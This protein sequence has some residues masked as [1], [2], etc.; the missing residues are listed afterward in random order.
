MKV[1]RQQMG[2]EVFF[3]VSDLSPV[4]EQAVSA[5]AFR[6]MEGT[7]DG[8][9]M[10]GYPADSPHLDH[11]FAN[12]ERSIETLIRQKAG[13]IPVAW[14]EALLYTLEK[15]EGQNIDWWMCGSAALAVRGI[16]NAP[17]DIDLITNNGDALKVGVLLHDT[18]IQPV[19]DSTGWFGK[20]FGRAFKGALIEWLDSVVESADAHGLTDF[21]PAA[22]SRLEV[23]RWNGYDIRVPPLDLQVAVNERR[24]RTER[25]AKIRAAMPGN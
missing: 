13:E 12:F 5:L 11:Y 24:G 6:P 4:Y 18:M 14:E 17:G 20:W 9:F 1:F 7:I 25:A 8:M 3:V 16:D 22:A 23:V 15:L 10:R 21:G 2:D 19:Q